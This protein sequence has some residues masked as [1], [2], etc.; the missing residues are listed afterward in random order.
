[1]KK[2]LALGFCSSALL[3]AA[4]CSPNTPDAISPD[5]ATEGSALQAPLSSS[6]QA[7]QQ[8]LPTP[9]ESGIDLSA[10]DLNVR[11]QDDF[12][13]YVNGTWLKNNEV[14]ADRTS[15]GIFYDLREQAD[16]N[17]RT[18]IN[19]LAA[20]DDLEDGSDEQ[21]VAALYRSVMD[22]E[23]INQ[24]GL[25]PLNAELAAIDALRNR[26]D[27]VRYFGY[28]TT[29]GIPSPLVPYVSI[30]AK[31]AT[32]YAAH[33]YQSGLSLPD[34]DFY[35]NPEA[36]YVALRTDL[37]QH[38]SN[39][40]AL[41]EFEQPEQAAQTI[42]E[43]ETA[44][45]EFHNTRVQNRD[46]AKAYNNIS[47]EQLPQLSALDWQAYLEGA[48][49]NNIDY[50]IVNQ[51][52]YIEA[53]GDILARF[54]LPQWQTY[55]RWQLLNSAAPLLSQAFEEQHFDF[56]KRKLNGQQEMQARWKN[57]VGIVNQYLGEVVGKIYVAKHFTPA[58]KERM[59][60][61]VENLRQAYGL[62]IDELTWMGPETK[63]KAKAKLAAFTPKIGYPE[64]WQDYSPLTID[65][66]DLFGNQQR[67]AQFA[68]QLD[69]AKIGGPIHTWEWH[70]TPQTVN[71]YYSPTANEIVFP[72]AILQPPFFNM[73][74]DDAVNYG[75]IGAV[76]G[77][78]MGHGFDDQGAR[79]DGEGN[80]NNWWTEQDLA[81]FQALGS[82]LVNQYDTFAVFPDLKVNGRLTLGENI[83]DL[84]GVT[85]GYKAYQLSLKNQAAPMM[86]ALTGEQRF[87]I[88]FAQIWRAKYQE[89]SLRNRVATDS[90]SPAQF[91]TN[92][93]L[94][95]VDAFY[96]A[97]DVQPGDQM[98]L[99]PAKRVK[100]W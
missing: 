41:A 22:T 33:L 77:H 71:A 47:R 53:L 2:T 55:Q 44:L 99:E 30:D 6:A 51:P 25:T 10:F 89:A 95:N 80:L 79:Y 39:M 96:E 8:A 35:F 54:T 70:M 14:P 45:A 88:S 64:K 21:K 29:V 42:L 56:F 19:E 92:G 97:F 94:P 27:L 7:V 13:N 4:G 78:E 75:G 91:R 62:S 58:A 61:L 86:D 50:L 66:M 63:L 72:A 17:V 24:L 18:I 12:F 73:A 52:A 43:I 93:P 85:I 26:S 68:H 36:R 23:T 20:R 81:Q 3:L 69:L 82:E 9:L 98:Y 59:S 65:G 90:H 1:M 11:P 84:S 48:G 49:L 83:G 76:I 38:I 5:A 31:N 57:A 74:A 28:A 40:F 87:F 32:T 60:V 37:Q 34:R 100:I 67:T 16:E 15:T 46:R